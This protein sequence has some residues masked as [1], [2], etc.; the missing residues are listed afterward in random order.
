MSWLFVKCQGHS[1]PT[2]LLLGQL[3]DHL[4]AS[5]DSAQEGPDGGD[6]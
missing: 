1:N 3:A 4:I 2:P 6:S 5:V